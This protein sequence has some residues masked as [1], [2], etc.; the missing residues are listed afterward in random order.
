MKI[1][2]EEIKQFLEGQDDEKYIVA[3]EYDYPT[4]SIYKIKEA[5][6]ECY[7]SPYSEIGKRRLRRSWDI[8]ISN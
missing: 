1:P 3:L 2:Q 6:K 7:Y 4:N 5:W 8:L